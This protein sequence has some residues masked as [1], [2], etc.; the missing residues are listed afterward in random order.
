MTDVQQDSNDQR[1]LTA[2][3]APLDAAGKSLA[4]ALRSSFGI[5]KALMMVLVVLYLFSNVRSVESHEQALLLRMGRLLPG[6]H[7]A[8][9]VWAFPFPIDEI[10]PLP[11]RKS[12][13]LRLDKSH[14]F[15]RRPDEIGKPLSF[16][17]RGARSGL[18]PGLDGSLL[19]ADGGLVHTEWK[20][21]YKM[22]DVSSYVSNIMGRKVEAAE[23]LL[24]ILAETTGIH[25]A[26]E[27]TAE[28]MI[29]TQVDDVQGE[30]RQRINERLKALKSGITVSRVEMYNPTPPI[31]VRKAFDQTQRAENAKQKHVR[32]AE[33]KRTTILSEAAG[34]A[35]PKLI[36][37]L[38]D[39]DAATEEPQRLDALS[40]ELDRML[41][42]DIEGEVGR[43]IKD[44]GTYLSLIVG[45]MR[46]DVELYRALVP[47]FQHNPLLLINRLWEQTR[48]IIFASSGVT[49]IYRPSGTEI[50]IT[51]A[52]D[53]EQARVDEERRLQKQEFDVSQL[54]PERLVPVG[55]EYD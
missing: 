14:T 10:V 28:Q 11:T 42:E 2:T 3:E 35:Y 48:Q 20:I 54:Q 26:L 33:Q 38:D 46:S 51:V 25:V 4:D 50:R 41:E 53:P 6:V 55:W 37:L 39:I 36:K 1:D 16:I 17:S 47:E 40:A 34:A 21:T 12:N 29:R 8:G 49:K 30:M 32:D 7:E 5:L 52:L 27:R 9:L 45:Q 23:D 31:P 24:R 22:D 19:T 43:R 18:K 13:E 15:A 44:A